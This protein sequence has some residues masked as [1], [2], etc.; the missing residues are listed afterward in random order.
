MNRTEFL[1]EIKC[2]IESEVGCTTKTTPKKGEGFVPYNRFNIKWGQMD[3]DLRKNHIRL[4]F[5][6]KPGFLSVEEFSE[7]TGLP[8]TPPGRI[9][10]GYRFTKAKNTPGHDQLIIFL[11]DNY[12]V[13]KPDALNE[14]FL[15]TK[16][17]TL[18]SSFKTQSSS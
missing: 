1:K 9:S 15:Y 8:I 3:A 6:L 5:D 4:V 16:E 18:Q 2:I 14:I 7:R 13:E 10:T 17:F 11:E 12:L